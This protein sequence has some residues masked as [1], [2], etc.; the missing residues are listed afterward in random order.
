MKTCLILSLLFHAG[1]FLGLQMV[2]PGS[3]IARPLRTYNVELFRPPIDSLD[4]EEITKDDLAGLS[5]EKM[6]TQEKTEDTISLDTKDK[7]YTHYARI[8]KESLMRH[9]AYPIYARENLIE[10]E[11]M[12]V[13]SLNRLGRLEDIRILLP[14]AFDILNVE[15]TRAIQ[16]A[17]PF[18]AFPGSVT[19]EKLNIKASFVYRLT[20]ASR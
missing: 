11:V 5:P 17:A 1:A 19:V 6:P 4:I 7:R 15:A 8:I 18:P 9:W 20:A 13:F 14:S 2:F 10:G 12:A 3:W 16:A